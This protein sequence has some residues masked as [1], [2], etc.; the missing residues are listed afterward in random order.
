MSHPESAKVQK[1]ITPEAVSQ[2]L[3]D[4]VDIKSPTGSEAG[5]AQYIVDRMRGGGFDAELQLVEAGRPNAVAH[6]RGK[7]TGLNLLFTGHMDTSYSGDEEHLVGEGFRP[8]GVFRDGWVWG[9]GA[10]NMKSGLTGLIVAMEAIAQSGVTLKGDLSLGAV[11]GE[12]EKAPAEEFQ[13][14]EYSGYGVGSKHLV[15]HGVTADFALLAEPT[16]L[17]ICTANMG[18]LW[19]RITLSGSVAHS[20]LTNKVGTVNAIDVARALCNDLDVWAKQFKET[21]VYMG[22]HANVTLACIRAGAPWRLSRNPHEASVYLDIRTV[23]GQSSEDIK[24]DLRGVLRAFAE[25]Q[26]MHEPV[27]TFSVTDPPLQIDETLPV[28]AALKDA[29]RAVMG[30]ATKPFLRRPGSDAVHL[31][32]YGVPCVQ[33]G[34]GGRLH[35]DAKGRSMHEVGDHVLLDDV[36]LAARIYAETALTVCNQPAR[37]AA[38]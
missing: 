33:F 5:M 3:L 29:Q 14:P 30:E 9:L 19:A 13:G 32:A 6:L 34:P 12:I 10:N 16:A 38:G 11:V 24:R 36:V 17:R 35:S 1:L 27:L 22:E 31:T 20:A 18:C 23:P 7:G 37:P 26:G 28:V 15:S 25:R 4:M 8:K 21:H 2:A